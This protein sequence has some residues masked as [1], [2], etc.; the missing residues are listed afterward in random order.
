MKSK[1]KTPDK[2][3]K[4]TVAEIKEMIL[5]DSPKIEYGRYNITAP[6]I[7]MEKLSEEVNE[8]RSTAVT[9]F[10]LKELEDKDLKR[11]QKALAKDLAIFNK[12]S[13]KIVKGYDY[14]H[15]K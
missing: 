3:I 2:K 1:K 11:K 6:K 8:P 5:R 7:V 9:R 10:V 15:I 14:S 13:L 12:E 4:Y